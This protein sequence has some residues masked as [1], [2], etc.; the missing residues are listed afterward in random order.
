MFCLSESE[1]SIGFVEVFFIFFGVEIEKSRTDRLVMEN[2]WWKLVWVFMYELYDECFYLW[3][4]WGFFGRKSVFR[5][6][7]QVELSL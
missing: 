5:L 4:D 1:K 3:D 2:F 7:D 6:S